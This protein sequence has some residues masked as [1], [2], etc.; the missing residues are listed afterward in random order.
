MN[1]DDLTPAPE[2]LTAALADTPPVSSD[3]REAA[4]ARALDVFDR[5]HTAPNVVAFPNRRRWYRPVAAAAA[6]VLLGVVTIGAINGLGG[7]DS[8]MSSSGTVATD[9]AAAETARSA[10]D[11]MPTGMV[12]GGG[13]ES[14]IDAINATA[15]VVPDIAT[16]DQ[17]RALPIAESAPSTMAAA[18]TTA[19]SGAVTTP[20]AAYT[21]L[22]FAFDC[23]LTADQVVLGAITWQGQPAAAVRDTVTG[24]TQAVDPQCNVLASVEP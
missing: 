15:I 16:E 12:A 22:G 19:H 6:V 17:L 21:Q 20:P 4:I 13:A 5:M 1:D 8:D 10:A 24:V 18:E 7:S 14:T 3:A 9:A 23:P 11:S 2:W